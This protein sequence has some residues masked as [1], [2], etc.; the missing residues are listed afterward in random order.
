MSRLDQAEKRISE[1][2]DTSYEIIQQLSKKQKRMKKSEG[3][4]QC[5]LR[6][7]IKRKNLCIIGI[8]EA[9]ERDKVA[10]SLFKK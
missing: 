1:F 6:D 9:E 10:E 5:E 3:S 2:E 8:P 4:S 7:T